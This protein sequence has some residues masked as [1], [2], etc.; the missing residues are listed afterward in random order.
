MGRRVRTR[1]MAADGTNR[2]GLLDF[3]E[4]SR[5]PH[6]VGDVINGAREVLFQVPHE[7]PGGH[8]WYLVQQ[9][10]NPV[11]D[12]CGSEE[13]IDVASTARKLADSQVREWLED[14][15]IGRSPRSTRIQTP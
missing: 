8:V 4:F 3:T 10:L 2:G 5:H 13:A 15:S 1:V 12:E 7:P 11:L 14:N 9:A 6:W